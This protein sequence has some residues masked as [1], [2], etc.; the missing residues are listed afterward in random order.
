MTLDDVA[1]LLSPRGREALA[2]ARSS[3]AVPA[4]ERRTALE[5]AGFTAPEAR[6]A[7]AGDDLRVHAA[8]KTRDADVLLFTREALEQA[9]PEAVATERARRFAPFASVAD[10]GAGVGLDSIALARAGCRVVAVERDAVRAALLA[11]NVAAVGLDDRIHVVVAD[12][13]AAPP[14]ADAAFLDPDRR[15]DGTRTHDPDAAE[16]PRAQWPALAARYRGMLVKVAPATPPETLGPGAEWVSLDGAMR[17]ARVGFGALA[18]PAARRALR[19]PSGATVE[20]TG[21]PWPSPR[22][23]RVGDVLLDPDPAVVVAGL[24]GEAFEAAG[25]SPMH[26]RIAYGLAAAPAPWA[27]RALRVDAVLP[28]DP[29]AVR[30][31]LD[32]RGLGDVEVLERGVED[33]AAT[34]RRRIGVRRGPRG[35][36][37]VTRGPDDR[38]LVLLG[39][40]VGGTAGA[41]EGT[42]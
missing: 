16:P 29:R 23:P 3:R 38:Y 8:A 10:L 11:H 2:A 24:V 5:R 35:T 39:S 7:L 41:S 36:V 4:L 9:T 17:E 19:L 13:A 32:A 20:G 1:F 28:A 26:P 27:E 42:S 31:A 25:A 6:A 21:R 22:A 40:R 14:E 30:A 37:V 18:I 34:W 15:P 33:P 12:F